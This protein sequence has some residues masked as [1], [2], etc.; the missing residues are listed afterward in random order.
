[1]ERSLKEGVA[2]LMHAFEPEAARLLSLLLP[3]AGWESAQQT[4]TRLLHHHAHAIGALLWLGCW[5]CASGPMTVPAHSVGLFA[6][7]GPVLAA[8]SSRRWQSCRRP[9]SRA[10][11]RG[12][13][14]ASALTAEVAVP[15]IDHEHD[16]EAAFCGREGECGCLGGV[17][18]TPGMSHAG[19]AQTAYVGGSAGLHCCQAGVARAAPAA[20]PA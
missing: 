18:G 13:P 1:M 16:E 20:A 17:G 3:G 8:R 7:P 19:R 14:Q 6:K 11:L 4:P 9:A 2:A 12:R 10:A 5:P 15:P